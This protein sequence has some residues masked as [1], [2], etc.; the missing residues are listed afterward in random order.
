MMILS[1]PALHRDLK[2][3]RIKTIQA[4]MNLCTS[5][6]RQDGATDGIPEQ[7]LARQYSIP[8]FNLMNGNNT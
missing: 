3:K 5:L 1:K 6:T 7:L 4:Y 8:G 2:M